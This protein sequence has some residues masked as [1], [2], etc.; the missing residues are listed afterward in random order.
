MGGGSTWEPECEQETSFGGRSRTSI[1]HK[2]YLVGKIYELIGNKMH[3]RLE[4]NLSLFVLGEDG[5]LYYKGKPLMNRNGELKTIG[6]IVDTFGIGGL[7]E[8][9]YNISKTNLKPQFVLDLME[10]QTKLPSSSEKA[11]VNEIELEEIAKSTK[12]LIFQINSQSQTDELYSNI[13]YASC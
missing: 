12:N 6:V 10:K 7:R 9:G 5:R 1:L 3:Q 11:G 13:L 2:E 4:L 8:V